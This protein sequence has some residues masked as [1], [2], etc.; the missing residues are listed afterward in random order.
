MVAPNITVEEAASRLGVSSATVKRLL[1]NGQISGQKLGGRWLVHG[2]KLPRREAT[3]V[4]ASGNTS[5]DVKQAFRHVLRQDRRDIWIPDVLNWEDYQAFPDAILDSAAGKCASGQADVLE[6]VEV[7][8]GELLSRAGTLLTLPDRVAFQALCGTFARRADSALMDCVFS[9]RLNQNG[10]GDFFKASFAQW[11]AFNTYV[12]DQIGSHGPWLVKTDLVSYFETIGHQLLI[13]DLQALGVETT[14]LKPL[15][16]LLKNWRQDS[17]HG[18]PIGTDA[19]RLL[20]N[21]FLAS[22][23]ESM[24]EQ[25]YNYSR[26]MDNIRIVAPTRLDALKGLRQ[27]EVFCRQ[28]G[29][30]VSGAKTSIE[31]VDL[32]SD[33]WLETD[34]LGMADYFFKNGLTETRL[35]LRK[36]LKGA[37]AEKQVKKKHARFA[38]LRLGTLV[39]RGV[40]TKV[41]ARLDALP[42][43]SKDSAFYLRGFISEKSVKDALTEYLSGPS[44]P[45][46]EVYQQAWLIAAMLEVVGDPPPEWTNYARRLA[47][48]ANNPDFLR[49]LAFNMLVLGAKH[50]DIEAVRL[51]VQRE[52]NPALVRGGLVALRRV[53]SLDRAT[54]SVVDGKFPQLRGTLT[55]LI[56]RESLPSLIQEG[57]WSSLRGQRTS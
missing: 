7:P 45:G 46:V 5:A 24:V 51:M 52:Y 48:D 36:I 44:D 38:L 23:D 6:I 9:S 42:E 22:V 50:T 25:G 13:Q 32:M 49:A 43:L 3:T 14:T 27:F 31:E 15:R 56:P 37:L 39:D 2:N 21:F 53:D 29:L 40:L 41:L 57:L 17:H 35:A 30:I 11:Q 10:R 55:Y 19:A 28:R 34:Q 18:L 12:E 4:E 20:G 16:D 26:Y 54:Q 47:W 1:S 8:K 33:S